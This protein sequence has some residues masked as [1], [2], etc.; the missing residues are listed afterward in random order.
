MARCYLV[1]MTLCSGSCYSSRR[2]R[3][4]LLPNTSMW[5]PAPP[6]MGVGLLL[7]P[8][9]F[10]ATYLRE[11]AT[12]K[13]GFPP[14]AG[15]A[16]LTSASIPA[17]LLD[18]Q[19]LP[20]EKTTPVTWV[21]PLWYGFDRHEEASASAS[22]NPILVCLEHPHLH[23]GVQLLTLVQQHPIFTMGS[24]SSRWCSS[25]PSSRWG[26]YARRP[27]LHNGISAFSVTPVY[28]ICCWSGGAPRKRT[29]HRCA[30]AYGT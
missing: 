26:A 20:V 22:C 13:R 24:H 9:G 7:V 30:C 1:V 27:H 2:I 15:K 3:I 28:Q 25:T 23:D 8:P 17:M 12:E 14:I 29:S 19:C 21:T 6:T 4:L 11:D 18:R 10:A 5:E 16:L